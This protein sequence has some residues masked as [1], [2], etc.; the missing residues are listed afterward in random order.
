MASL[1][2]ASLA[3]ERRSSPPGHRNGPGRCIVPE[4]RRPALCGVRPGT[5]GVLRAAPASR[6]RPAL[7]GRAGFRGHGGCAAPSRAGAS[8]C[9]RLAPGSALARRPSAACREGSP[10]RIRG[11]DSPS[12]W[13]VPARAG[14]PSPRPATTRGA[15]GRAERTSSR[16]RHLV[17]RWRGLPG[18]PRRGRSPRVPCAADRP[19]AGGPCAGSRWSQP[20]FT[21][22][23]G[24][25]GCRMV[26]S[27][28][29]GDLTVSS[30]AARSL[31]PAS[32]ARSL[33]R[34]RATWL[35]TRC[36]SRSTPS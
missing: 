30:R 2:G 11:N 31:R 22:V 19:A 33:V 26:A 27:L 36:G 29:G 28:H 14:Q 35:S 34:P 8:A 32:R 5:C 24:E 18:P 23:E 15:P 12:P 9:A 1:A 4:A 7:T 13:Q 17:R 20:P 25:P 10:D 3:S 6:G 16:W 21:R